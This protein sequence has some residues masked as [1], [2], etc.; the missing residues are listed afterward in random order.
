M[1]T[2]E[3]GLLRLAVAP[4]VGAGVADFSIR[5]PGG[6]YFP[7]MRRAAPEEGSASL[8]GSFFMA[9]W[10]NRIR[11]GRFVFGGR[12][13]AIRTN[14]ADGMAQHGD[15]RKRAWRVLDRS[16][17]TA[18]FEFDSREHGDVNWPWPFLCRARYGL[19]GSASGGSLDGRLSVRNLGS[20]PMPAACGHHP[21]FMRRLWNDRDEIEVRVPVAGRYPLEHGC[22]VGAASDDDL[23]RRLRAGG[24]IPAGPIDDVFVAAGGGEGAGGAELR[25]PASGVTLRIKPS[26]NMGHWVVYA[27]QENERVISSLS[28]VAVEPQTAVNDAL[29]LAGRGVAGT[30]TVV[31]GAGEELETGCR[32]EVGR[33]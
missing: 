5:G 18:S 1:I 12:E 9:P 29:N 13:H 10:V 7:I 33:S 15:V 32:F 23:T 3:S 22:A 20:E 25:W 8:L 11:G 19:D 30:G 27:P 28:F 2:L 4:N 6:F 16:P 21:Y 17:A 26:A 14:T 31:L 24:P